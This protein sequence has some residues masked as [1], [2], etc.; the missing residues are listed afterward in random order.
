MLFVKFFNTQEHTFPLSDT[1]TVAPDVLK[2]LGVEE[3][4]TLELCSTQLSQGTFAS[5]QARTSNWFLLGKDERQALLEM[6][7]RKLPILS[8]G[9]TLSFGYRFEVRFAVLS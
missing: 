8:E 5:F 3:G 7:L 2:R 1:V 9:H 6:E 4:Q